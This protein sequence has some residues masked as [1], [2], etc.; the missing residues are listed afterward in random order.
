MGLK[1]SLGTN[2][3]LNIFFTPYRNPS[4]VVRSSFLCRLCQKQAMK[5][6]RQ[7]FIPSQFPFFNANL[8]YSLSCRCYNLGPFGINFTVC[9]KLLSV[10]LRKTIQLFLQAVYGVSCKVVSQSESDQGQRGL[11]SLT[12]MNAHNSQF[13][14]KPIFCKNIDE[15][16]F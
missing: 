4:T 5:S 3:M 16:W 2:R 12:R 13:A 9:Y 14:T 11:P 7:I 10:L 15:H 8:I 1:Q 6:R